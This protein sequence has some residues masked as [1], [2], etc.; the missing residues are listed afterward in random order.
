M[1]KL[2]MQIVNRV[3]VNIMQIRKQLPN[4]LSEVKRSKSVLAQRSNHARNTSCIYK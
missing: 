3:D 4:C 1:N 2:N